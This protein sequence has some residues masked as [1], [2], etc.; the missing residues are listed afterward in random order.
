MRKTLFFVLITFCF[1]LSYSQKSNDYTHSDKL[2]LEAKELYDLQ[3]YSAAYQKFNK[4]IESQTKDRSVLYGQA[5]Y[6]IA[7]C[8]Y[9]MGEKNAGKLLQNFLQNNSTST[10]TNRTHYLKGSLSYL[11]GSYAEATTEYEMVDAS[12]LKEDENSEFLF[13][14]GYAYLQQKQYAKAKE[15]F[16]ALKQDSSKYNQSAL[17]YKA[18]VDYVEKNY[19]EAMPVFQSLKDDPSYSTIVPYYI[20]QIEYA[21]KNY[22]AVLSSGEELLQKNPDNENNKE[23]Q[24]I[25]GECYYEKKD[26]KNTVKYLTMYQSNGGQVI[27]NDMYMLGIS[28]YQEGDFVEAI[29]CFQSVATVEDAL[30][31]NAYLY[32]G[33]CYVKDENFNNARLCFESASRMDYDKNVKE[34][35][36]YNYALIVYEQSYSP[37]NESINAFES[38]LDE[39]KTSRYRDKVHGY[40]VNLYMTTKNYSE[41]L[42]SIEKIENRSLQIYE[43]RQ[44][45][46]Y[47]LGIQ[48]INNA[49]YNEAVQYFSESLKDAKYDAQTESEATFW[50]GEAYYRLKDYD[51]AS[52]DFS[53]F[54]NST[55]AR[56]CSE[57]NLGHYNMGYTYFTQK[58]YDTALTW[59]RKYLDLEKENKTLIADAT[60][61]VGDCYFNQKNYDKAASS[62][63]SVY[64]M[65]GPG[66]DYACFQ[67]G[68]IQGLQKDYNG[69]ISTLN[70]LISTFPQSEYISD[71]KYEIGRSYVM[72]GENQK[73]IDTYEKL[74]NEYPHSPLSRKGKLQTAMLYEEMDKTDKAVSTY[75]EIVKYFPTSVEAKTAIESLKNIYFEQNDIQGYA[76]YVSSLDGLAKFDQSEQDSLTYLAAE[77]L[78][79]MEN[80]E[81]AASAF[82]SYIQKY[83]NSFFVTRAKSNLADCY[84]KLNKMDLAEAEYEKVASEV[85]SPDREEALARLSEIQYNNQ[86]YAKAIASMSVLDSIAQNAENKQA[87]RIGLLRC[88]KLLGKTDE[89]IEAANTIINSDK[90]DPNVQREAL[91]ARAKA[92]EVKGDTAAAF[93]DYLSLSYNCM[94]E[95][96]AESKFRV[97]ESYYNQADYMKAEKEIFDFIDVNTPHQYWLAKG[98]ILLSDVYVKLNRDFEA[99]QYLVSVREN[100]SGKDDI[101]SEIKVRLAQIEAREAEKVV[102][103]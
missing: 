50:R 72:M 84:Y 81:K 1:S 76:D 32:L 15:K 45:I 11:K 79:G 100:Y 89:T 44:R 17:Y 102:K 83:P 23:V 38:F 28:N 29:E 35:A 66:A 75:K 51:K 58:N 95:Y 74:N 34:E 99:K 14:C 24:R 13:R 2:F 63:A 25:L 5:Q 96:G 41:A 88:N 62:Y 54:V 37:F 101:S 68:F 78:Y 93:K 18:Y 31:Q 10:F 69:K 73:A 85:G 57:Y 21:Q 52:S 86:N 33:S 97:A 64:S 48:S 4:Y 20:F 65:K 90:L 8:A 30:G 67:Q 6:Y 39:F 7:S 9:E 43:A 98:F 46:N 40:M 94:D 103:E 49:D 55:G 12:R 71:A 47:N 70:K 53:S 3:H 87:A 16:V 59:F 80:Y 77:R 36:K 19:E 56:A 91:Y 22:E 42:K 26:Y 60:N 27:R 61:R 82:Q 92:Q